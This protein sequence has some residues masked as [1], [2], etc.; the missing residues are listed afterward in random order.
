MWL[1]VVSQRHWENQEATI[2]YQEKNVQEM[3]REKI[4]QCELQF[5]ST[6]FPAIK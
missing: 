4:S 6:E 5:I 2:Q 3:E 1:K